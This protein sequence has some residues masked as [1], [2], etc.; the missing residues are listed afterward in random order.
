MTG[1][2]PEANRRVANLEKL[3]SSLRCKCKGRN[4]NDVM[5]TIRE[6][7]KSE[8]L[9]WL[10]D[11]VRATRMTSHQAQRD[12]IMRQADDGAIVVGGPAPPF[13]RSVLLEWLAVIFGRLGR[14]V[15]MILAP[16]AEPD[17]LQRLTQLKV[18]ISFL[19]QYLGPSGPAPAP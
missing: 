15:A 13:E 16:K 8:N 9:S 19:R 14:E 10:P 17:L 2:I 3:M 6:I 5:P 7:A 11:M 18:R 12:R 1:A 4:Y